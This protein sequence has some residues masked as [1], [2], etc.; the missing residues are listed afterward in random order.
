MASCYNCL[1]C[2][3]RRAFCDMGW[4]VGD[5]E[6]D[7]NPQGEWVKSVSVCPQFQPNPSTQNNDGDPSNP[8]DSGCFLTSACV[9][10]MVKEDDCFELTTLRNFRDT[11]M[12]KQEGGQADIDH[13]YKVAPEIVKTIDARSDRLDIYQG[14]Y[15]SLVAPCVRL[16]GDGKFEEAWSLYRIMTLEYSRIYCA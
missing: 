1:F 5:W 3:G 7:K 6:P 8:P 9:D 2:R 13:Y 15:D 16:I 4:Y 10:A 14:M 11:W 12:A